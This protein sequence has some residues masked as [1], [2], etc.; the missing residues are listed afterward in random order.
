MFLEDP[1]PTIVSEIMALKFDLVG[2]ECC[3]QQD[4]GV[5]GV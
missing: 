4:M 5:V 1:I 2:P 3:F